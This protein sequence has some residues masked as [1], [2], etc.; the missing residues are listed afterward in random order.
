MLK[1][2]VCGGRSYADFTAICAALLKV[3]CS[4]GITE[5]IH[6]GVSG[7]DALANTWAVK[8]GVPVKS[9]PP[10]YDKHGEEA[11][12]I[13]N[14]SMITEGK[15]HLIIAFYG[16]P[17][18]KDLLERAGKAGLPIWRPADESLEPEL[19]RSMRLRHLR[20]YELDR[21]RQLT[22]E[23]DNCPVSASAPSRGI[24]TA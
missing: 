18:T 7:A 20:E 10:D 17:G 14:N 16:G 5:I 15:P 1:V 23:A 8:H 22:D 24:V 12:T 11:V 3:R 4:L 9:Y 2:I 6:G 13:R 21:A 19:I